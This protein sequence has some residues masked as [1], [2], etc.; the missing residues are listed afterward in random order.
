MYQI[1]S[2]SSASK[3]TD[4]ETEII[5]IKFFYS[6]LAVLQGKQT[7]NMLKKNFDV[8]RNNIKN[9]P[10]NQNTIVTVFNTL[11]NM[12]FWELMGFGLSLEAFY[13]LIK[14]TYIIITKNE[15][16]KVLR[17]RTETIAISY[18]IN[19]FINLFLEKNSSV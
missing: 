7:F 16:S 14:E 6:I 10:P 8:F 17:H 13:D 18:I 15:K 11:T 2:K 12:G 4:E 1:K 9:A 19:N 3:K 5:F